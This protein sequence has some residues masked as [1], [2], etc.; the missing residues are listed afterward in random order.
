[1]TYRNSPLDHIPPSPTGSRPWR[2]LD[3]RG[4]TLV[5]L[6]VITAILGVLVLM[7]IPTYGVMKDKARVARCMSEMRDLEKMVTA[8][9]IDNGG[10][11]P[12][13]LAAIGQGDFRD[14]WGHVYEYRNPSERT[15]VGIKINKDF[16]LWS[17]GADGAS[18]PD[19]S[20]INDPVCLDDIIRFNEGAQVGLVSNFLGE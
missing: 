3:R 11:Y 5:E 7:A 4:F 15:D 2:R 6:I 17:K 12:P 18:S 16:D 9:S 19:P 1:M 10:S 13:N 14:P 20:D 8:W